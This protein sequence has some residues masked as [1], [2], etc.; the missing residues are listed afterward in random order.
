MAQVKTWWLTGQTVV[1]CVIPST[2]A[3]CYP[4]LVKLRTGSAP[5]QRRMALW[6]M[7]ALLP[8]L[9]FFGH[10]PTHIDIPGTGLYLTVP[11]A[12]PIQDDATE[13]DHAQHCHG[14]AS[15]CS[16]TPATAGVGFAIMNETIAALGAAALLVAVASRTRTLRAPRGVTPELPP[17]R[18]VL[19]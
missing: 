1:T 5:T 9:T 6:L 3:H 18:T 10:W 8:M 15:G 7:L 4:S 11:F 14:E 16:K 2:P 12:G 17:P 13:H 19:A